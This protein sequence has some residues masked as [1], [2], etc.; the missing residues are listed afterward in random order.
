MAHSK[1][2][3]QDGQFYKFS[4]ISHYHQL[5]RQF[6]I[7]VIASYVGR[8]EGLENKIKIKNGEIEQLLGKEAIAF[9]KYTTQIMNLANSNAQGTRPKVV[10]QMSD[11]IE[12][13]DGD[14]LSDWEKWYKNRK[15]TAINDATEKVSQMVEQ[16]KAAIIQIDNALKM[17]N[18]KLNINMAM[19]YRVYG[20]RYDKIRK[21]C[22]RSLSG[23]FFKLIP[24]SFF[25]FIQSIYENCI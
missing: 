7:I 24:K 11:L 4:I 15:P 25:R 23:F 19:M 12:E 21:Y 18:R 10:G 2:W 5:P 8:I 1:V 13:F 6:I 17:T 22:C 3:H 14:D 20:F 16:L 9:P